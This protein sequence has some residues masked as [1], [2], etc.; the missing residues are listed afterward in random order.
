MMFCA[1]Y[2]FDQAYRTLVLDYT[3]VLWSPDG[4]QIT[5]TFDIMKFSATTNIS[6]PAYSGLVLVDADGTH[7]RA[8]LLPETTRQ[9]TALQW[10]IS[11]VGSP[12]GAAKQSVGDFITLPPALTY[13]WNAAGQLAAG[14]AL[15]ASPAAAAP[16]GDPDGG[17]S[18]T[19]WQPGQIGFYTKDY[20][21]NGSPA[22]IN[23]GIYTLQTA[24]AAWSPDGRYL[25]DS[26]S[27]FGIVH[28]AGEPTP[29]AAGVH[30]LLGTDTIPTL[31]IRD[32]ALQHALVAMNSGGNGGGQDGIDLDEIAWSPSGHVLAAFPDPAVDDHPGVSS[33]PVTLYNSASGKPMETLR[34]YSSAT[35]VS[36]N[37]DSN[38]STVYWS[39][40]GT[41]LLVYSDQQQTITIW[42]SIT[43]PQS[44]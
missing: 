30:A 16:A 14:A 8:A 7:E 27:L 42:G 38:L 35:A 24:F 41:H 29:T 36:E 25:I 4:Q 19:I 44:A 40:D 6:V 10:T 23:P 31:P 37:S 15:S 26:V 32:R 39:P 18:F 11:R 5:L 28:P 12:G 13:S 21:S 43:P 20:S 2:P 17:S 33:A 34:P 1:L 9:N 22:P 3:H